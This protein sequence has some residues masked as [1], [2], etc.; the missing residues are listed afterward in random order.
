[1][2]N[3]NST[4]WYSMHLKMELSFLSIGVKMEIEKQARQNRMSEPGPVQRKL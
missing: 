2:V 1:M 4:A 3:C